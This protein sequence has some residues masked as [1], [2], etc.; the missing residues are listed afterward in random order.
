MSAKYDL[1]SE[2]GQKY[3]DHKSARIKM[4]KKVLILKSNPVKR[5]ACWAHVRRKF[6]EDEL[7][8]PPALRMC[9]YL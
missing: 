5:I 6:V 3:Y 2:K 1:R 8:S 9:R 4:S 7:E